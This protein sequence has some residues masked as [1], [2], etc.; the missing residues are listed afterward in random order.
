MS[1]EA[2]AAAV[3][4]AFSIRLVLGVIVI[5]VASPSTCLGDGLISFN[6]QNF[7]NT[8]S[9]TPL[10]TTKQVGQDI[11]LCDAATPSPVGAVWYSTQIQVRGFYTEFTYTIS[12]Y[13]G[14][15]QRR[16]GLAFVLQLDSLNVIGPGGMGM[17]YGDYPG[18]SSNGSNKGITRSLAIEFDSF[19]DSEVQD[20]PPPPGGGPFHISVHTNGLNSN[21]ADESYSIW[22]S[23]QP[24]TTLG[25]Q[26]VGIRYEPLT[27]LVGRMTITFQ[28]TILGVFNITSLDVYLGLDPTQ[29]SAWVGFTASHSAP[30][31][32]FP[33]EDISLQSWTYQFLGKIAAANSI[34]YGLEATEAGQQLTFYLQTVDNYNYNMTTDSIKAS[35]A[36]VVITLAQPGPPINGTIDYRGEGLYKIGITGN[37]SGNATISLSL[38]ST[39]IGQG[40]YSYLIYPASPYPNTSFPYGSGLDTEV[41]AGTVNSFWIQLCDVF[42]NNVTANVSTPLFAVITPTFPGYPNQNVTITYD[43]ETGRHLAT[44]N[45]TMVGSYTIGVMVN[46]MPPA[47]PTHMLQV[48]PAGL[49]P[50]TSLLYGIPPNVTAGTLQQAWIQLRDSFLNNITEALTPPPN[51]TFHVLLGTLVVNA[52]IIP[53][54]NGKY[55]VTYNATT[56]G[57][58]YGFPIVN[59]VGTI[60]YNTP[61]LVTPNQVDPAQSYAYGLALTGST[62]GVTSSFVVQLTD[63]FGNNITSAE[64]VAVV[65]SFAGDFPQPTTTLLG[66]AYLISYTLTVAARYDLTVNVGTGIVGNGVQTV[67]IIPAAVSPIDSIGYGDGLTG[68]GLVVGLHQFYVQFRDRYLNNVTIKTDDPLLAQISDLHSSVIV[69]AST[70][71]QSSSGVYLVVYNITLASDYVASITVDNQAILNYQTNLTLI[72]GEIDPSQT[73][74]N[75]DL[76]SNATAGVIRTFTVQ[77]RD[78]FQ[79]NILSVPD[80]VT[81]TF[82]SPSDSTIF[83]VQ[84]TPAQNGLY[85]CAYNAT[86]KG[87]YT[88]T[89]HVNGTLISTYSVLVNPNIPYPPYCMAEGTGLDS[90]VAGDISYITIYLFDPFNNS[91]LEP[92][93]PPEVLIS[94][95]SGQEAHVTLVF[96]PS[97]VYIAVYNITT[98]ETY[99]VSIKVGGAQIK[100][101]PQVLTVAPDDLHVPNCLA[102]GDSL[103]NGV[104]GT[105]GI[106]TVQLRDEFGNNITN[107]ANVTILSFSMT[108]GGTPVAPPPPIQNTDGTYTFNYNVTVSGLYQITIQINENNILGSP[109]STSVSP[110]EFDQA[111]STVVGMDNMI[112]AGHPNSFSIQLRDVYG[113]IIDQEDIQLNEIILEFNGTSISNTQVTYINDG[114]YMVYYNYTKMGTVAP[115]ITILDRPIQQGVPESI[116][117]QADVAYAP[118]CYAIGDATTKAYVKRDN[119]FQVYIRDRYNNIHMWSDFPPTVALTATGEDTVTGSLT[120]QSDGSYQVMYYIYSQATY[121]MIITINDDPISGSPF[122]VST[123]YPNNSL[124]TLAI[125]GIVAGVLVAVGLAGFA[126]FRFY[127]HLHRDYIPI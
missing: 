28:R 77:L 124:S 34:V 24:Y 52:V 106:F 48:V 46:N 50:T 103:T 71:F 109:F 114:V 20:P 32:T 126:G 87:G 78:T 127:R 40:Q 105:P 107:Y 35:G 115:S 88:L 14:Q 39:P 15:Q 100:T 47:H 99:T 43:A 86:L 85:T 123:E 69:N 125:V 66:G 111:G 108:I 91:I 76:D 63:H 60:G 51:V 4:A 56:S 80:V 37:I 54:S 7:T 104:A 55:S 18:S 11:M 2:A 27:P 16:D 62:A 9:L 95:A 75:G 89:I 70:S 6:Y 49:N 38:G 5:L 25:Q 10:G 53:L 113:N 84:I 44:Y 90:S 74:L 120:N 13:S 83:D 67:V 22:L 21:N 79:N 98:S 23:T 17:G 102:F 1:L 58:Y 94:T 121:Q 101:P 119:M 61:I 122:S 12:N 36:Q 110:A 68:S 41:A 33:G 97:G 59:G 42:G 73:I 31:S 8:Q 82:E 72:P 92:V 26:T 19:Y 30:N 3:A 45:V 64:A 112:I 116:S 57:V 65:A 81:A 117:I 93:D 96:D 29:G 118:S